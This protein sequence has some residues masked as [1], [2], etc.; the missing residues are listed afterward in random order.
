MRARLIAHGASLRLRPP[1][2]PEKHERIRSS[3]GRSVRSR[4][5]TEEAEAAGSAQGAFTSGDRAPEW[6]PATLFPVTGFGGR[7]SRWVHGRKLGSPPP[8]TGPPLGN[9]CEW[10]TSTPFNAPSPCPAPGAA[11]RASPPTWR[12]VPPPA[13]WLS[14][15]GFLLSSYASGVGVG[16]SPSATGFPHA[17]SPRKPAEVSSY[18]DVRFPFCNNKWKGWNFCR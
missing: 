11:E 17:G 3:V 8:R 1:P 6:P 10:A 4:R 13:G 5:L 12:P 15:S 14:L 2:P 7:C 16:V 9:S 18:G